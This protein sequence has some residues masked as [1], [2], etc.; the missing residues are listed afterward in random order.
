M[1]EADEEGRTRK[2]WIRRRWRPLRRRSKRQRK[3]ELREPPSRLAAAP[4]TGPRRPACEVRKVDLWS[5]LKISLCFYLAAVVLVI[6]A[7]IVL[8]LDRRRR[9]RDPQHREVHGQ[10]PELEELPPRLGADPRGLDPRRARAGRADD[11][12]DA[13]SAPRSTTCSPSSSVAS[14]SRSW[15]PTAARSAWSATAG[16]SADPAGNLPAPARGYSSAG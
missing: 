8:W 7:G 5:V 2:A 15:R 12:P 10:D 16:P 14:R 4:R 6:V 9:R 3:R 1:L 11:D 13:S